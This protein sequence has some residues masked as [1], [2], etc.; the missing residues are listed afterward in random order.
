MSR[1]RQRF[2]ESELEI[3]L[4]KNATDDEIEATTRS[5][6]YWT[7]IVRFPDSTVAIWGRGRSC[8]ACE[9]NAVRLADIVAFEFYCSHDRW[10][11]G[12][13]RF[14]LWPPRPKETRAGSSQLIK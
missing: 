6:R 8:Q 10:P 2:S 12:R 11:L 3:L 4:S 13:W 9:R 14:V 5:S 1:C 7:Y